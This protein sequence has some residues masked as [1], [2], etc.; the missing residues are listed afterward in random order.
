MVALCTTAVSTAAGSIGEVI[1]IALYLILGSI[2]VVIAI[3]LY[4]I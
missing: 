3:A 1:A 4:L 2:R